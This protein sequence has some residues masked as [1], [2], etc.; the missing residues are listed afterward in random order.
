MAQAVENPP[1]IQGTGILSLDWKD[2]LE[3]GGFPG[4]SG[5]KESSCNAGD[6]GRFLGW[7]D[8]LEKG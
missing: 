4:S 7:E 3:K 5:A 6:P 2:R 8:P 1:T